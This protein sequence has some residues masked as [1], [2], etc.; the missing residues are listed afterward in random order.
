ME[1]EASEARNVLI[2]SN[3]FSEMVFQSWIMTAEVAK[4]GST[5]EKKL[6]D[7][8]T[9]VGGFHIYSAPKNIHPSTHKHECLEVRLATHH[10]I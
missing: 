5:E 3:W 7:Y 2:W 9:A 4:D 8:I 6:M 1:T 10:P